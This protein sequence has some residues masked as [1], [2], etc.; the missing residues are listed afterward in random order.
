MFEFRTKSLIKNNSYNS[1]FPKQNI[2]NRLKSYM[3]IEEINKSSAL[4]S[5]LTYNKRVRFNLL[6]PNEYKIITT[7]IKNE[8]KRK[9]MDNIDTFRKIY[10]NYNKNTKYSLEEIKDMSTRNQKFIKQYHDTVN[11]SSIINK[12]SFSEIKSEYEKQDYILPSLDKGKN[13]FKSNLLLLNNDYDLKK[14]IYFGMDKENNNKTLSF[15]EKMNNNIYNEVKDENRNEKINNQINNNIN[16]RYRRHHDFKSL[17]ALNKITKE[18]MK[19]I[20]NSKR[21]IIRIKRTIDSIPD[22]ENFFNSDNKEYLDNL[23]YFN[24]RNTSANFSTTFGNNN[25]TLFDKNNSFN[26]SNILSQKNIS[27]FTFDENDSII[28]QKNPTMKFNINS[29]TSNSLAKENNSLT[30]L[31]SIP[32]K[33]KKIIKRYL[34]R[35]NYKQN[36]E[37]LY[38]KIATSSDSTIYDKKIKN[39]LRF[40]RYRLDP[41]IS[42][43]KLCNNMEN[44]REVI[45]KDDSIKKVIY[46]RKNAGN[47]FEEDK[48]KLNEKESEI[49]K[50]VN[51]IEDQMIKAFSELKD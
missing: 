23:K 48:G 51:D 43:N 12:N 11:K 9:I 30:Q 4:S 36:L 24:S 26:K 16:N 13:L 2:I 39:Y 34:N 41:T 22:I 6:V 29:N 19:E 38:N 27:K 25:S 3:T 1:I 46:F 49:E 15:L 45:C 47:F 28:K 21:E 42:K 8:K 32:K 5:A 7:K 33:R 17:F 18:K 37:S 14:F 44:L 40:R 50:K 20:L 10:Y 35:N 31:I